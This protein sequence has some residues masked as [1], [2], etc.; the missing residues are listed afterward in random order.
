MEEEEMQVKGTENNFS[1]IIEENVFILQQE[2]PIK[3][4]KHTEN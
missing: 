4:K 2:V 3:L 1:K